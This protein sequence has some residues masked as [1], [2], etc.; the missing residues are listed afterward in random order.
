MNHKEKIDHCN[1]SLEACKC[2]ISSEVYDEIYEYINKYNEWGVGIEML[3]DVISEDETKINSD[4]FTKLQK[5]LEI[6]GLGQSERMK[7][8]FDCRENS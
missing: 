3:I 7:A 1:I 5:A 8:L 6:I 2:F 4:Q